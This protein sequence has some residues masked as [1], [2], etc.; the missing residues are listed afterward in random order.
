[1]QIF[2]QSFLCSL[3][4]NRVKLDF[5]SMKDSDWRL[6]SIWSR[7]LCCQPHLC[8]LLLR[9]RRCHSCRRHRRRR[10]RRRRRFDWIFTE[11]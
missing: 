9:R 4:V 1:M 11:S 10:R 8:R 3:E 2:L 7:R 6:S 5:F